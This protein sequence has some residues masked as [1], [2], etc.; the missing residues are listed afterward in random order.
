M[1]DESDSPEKE[2][3][4]PLRVEFSK[5][6]VRKARRV[7]AEQVVLAMQKVN[8]VAAAHATLGGS[9]ITFEG[10]EGRTLTGKTVRT[11]VAV[12]NG[13]IPPDLFDGL[14]N[15]FKGLDQDLKNDRSDDDSEP[16]DD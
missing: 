10:H 9:G 1:A 7:F 12:V 16:S 8:R 2:E 5:E 6:D 11:F 4:E 13:P 3:E 15:Y 14:V